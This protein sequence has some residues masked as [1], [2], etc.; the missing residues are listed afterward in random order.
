VGF[1]SGGEAMHRLAR[2]LVPAGRF[3]PAFLV[4]ASI[5]ALGLAADAAR[6]APATPLQVTYYYLPG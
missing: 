1:L 4:L 2:V 3:L 5:S 6:P